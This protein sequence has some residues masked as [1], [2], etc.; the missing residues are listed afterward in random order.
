MPLKLA[1]F[2][3]IDEFG[4]LQPLRIRQNRWWARPVTVEGAMPWHAPITENPGLGDTE[5]W[6]IYNVT[7]DAHPVHVHL[8]HFEVL[9]MS[10][11]A[12]SSPTRITR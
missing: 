12:I 6:E 7:E 3:D 4:R 1:L 2:E 8:V 10:G 11:T 5:I 9:N